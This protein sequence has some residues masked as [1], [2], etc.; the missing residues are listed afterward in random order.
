L[1]EKE[2][3]EKTIPVPLKEAQ[4][5]KHRSNPYSLVESFGMHART[6]GASLGVLTFF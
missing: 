2:N 6:Q 3:K 5:I 1:G 4:T